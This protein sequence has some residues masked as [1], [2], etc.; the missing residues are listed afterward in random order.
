MDREGWR[1]AIHGVAESD[2]TEWLNWTELLNQVICSLR[3]K[4]VIV[5][6]KNY[7]EDFITLWYK[8]HPIWTTDCN[9][10][11][12]FSKS[13]NIEKMEM[14]MSYITLNY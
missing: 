3:N 8:Y 11:K 4:E 5:S 2:T 13:R 12:L 6:E 10:I 9:V 7:G 1:T 14:A